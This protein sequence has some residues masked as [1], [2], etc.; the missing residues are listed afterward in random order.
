VSDAADSGVPTTASLMWF[1][2]GNYLARRLY[3][4]LE[5]GSYV[6]SGGGCRGGG[7]RILARMVFN[8]GAPRRERVSVVGD[9]AA[10]CGSRGLVFVVCQVKVRHLP[11]MGRG[12]TSP[13]R[14]RPGRELFYRRWY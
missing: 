2:L 1:G 13:R 7:G 5:G 6:L 10:K 12:A 3:L 9:D 11:D 14:L 8:V 4:P